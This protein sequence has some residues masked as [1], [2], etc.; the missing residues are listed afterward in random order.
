[1]EKNV[2]IF[3]GGRGAV[4]FKAVATFS[5]TIS[6][7]HKNVSRNVPFMPR[8]LTLFH[9]TKSLQCYKQKVRQTIG[10]TN[11]IGLLTLLSESKEAK[12]HFQ[13]PEC[14][15]ISIQNVH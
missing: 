5:H 3:W 7:L 6:H 9:E 13:I 10:K 11:N 12:L 15:I 1:M 4:I 8:L 2:K 14:R